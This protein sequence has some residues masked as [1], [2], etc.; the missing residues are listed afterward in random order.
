[1][2]LGVDVGVGE[3]A[4]RGRGPRAEAALTSLRSKM[5]LRRPSPAAPRRFSEP[6]AR[7][8]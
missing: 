8:A 5:E 4:G 3:R 1:M 2:G 6:A 7:A